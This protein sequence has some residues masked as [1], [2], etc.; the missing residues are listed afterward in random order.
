M[1][2]T[3]VHFDIDEDRDQMLE[4]LMR[5]PVSEALD[6]PSKVQWGSQSGNTFTGQMGDFMKPVIHIGKRKTFLCLIFS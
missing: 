3:L 6:I 2:R 1:Y 4:E 5:G